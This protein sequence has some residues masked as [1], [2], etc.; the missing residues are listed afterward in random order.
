MPLPTRA[1]AWAL[2][3]EWVQADSAVGHASGVTTPAAAEAA[4]LGQPSQGNVDIAALMCEGA[5]CL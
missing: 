3:C 1:E 2:V 5:V 4:S